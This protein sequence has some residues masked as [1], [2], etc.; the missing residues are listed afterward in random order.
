MPANSGV[1]LGLHVHAAV[2]MEV[3]ID[4]LTGNYFYLAR[5]YLVGVSHERR[6]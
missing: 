6:I 1:E 2:L 3:D 4:W 5:G